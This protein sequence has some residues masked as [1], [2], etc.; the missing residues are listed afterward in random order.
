MKLNPSKLININENI[1]LNLVRNYA[2]I[3]LNYT[4]GV[5]LSIEQIEKLIEAYNTKSEIKL[6]GQTTF[7]WIELKDDYM[8]MY[9]KLSER[10]IIHEKETK[11]IIIHLEEYF[12]TLIEFLGKND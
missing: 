1:K 5:M 4:K 6:K 7:S 9:S 8:Y 11:E 12:K 3:S 10:G 2:C